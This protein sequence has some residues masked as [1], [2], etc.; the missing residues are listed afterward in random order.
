MTASGDFMPVEEGQEF[1][2]GPA[3]PTVF[4]MQLTPPVQALAIVLL[5]VAASFALYNFLVRPVR[6]QI[7]A[8]QT[9]VNTVQAQV[10][11]QRASLQD[12]AVLQA[13]LDEVIQQRVAVYGLLGTSTSLETLLI[14]INQQI[15][16]S[17]AAIEDVLRSDFDRIDQG[18]LAGLG[19]NQA[20]IAR[21]RAEFAGDPVIQRVLYASELWEF[22]PTEVIPWAAAPVELEGKINSQSVSVSMQAL[23]P[24]TLNILRNIERLEPLIVIRDLEQEQAPL[25]AGISEEQVQGITRPLN[26]TF[27]LEVLVPAIDPTEPPPPPPPPEAEAGAEGAPPPEGG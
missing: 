14:D 6:Q 9:E 22:T 11:Q 21:I 10:D 25:R 12:L 1:D 17:N 20:Q 7:T 18:Q 24:Q 26:T 8:V 23:F 3:Y 13:Q 16:N 15:Q 2:L 4:G 27:T 5:G 19:L